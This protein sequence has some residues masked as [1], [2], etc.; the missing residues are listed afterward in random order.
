[1]QL[2]GDLTEAGTAQAPSPASGQGVQLNS[3]KLDLRAEALCDI[4]LLAVKGCLARRAGFFNTQISVGGRIAHCD[5][6]GQQSFR[7]GKC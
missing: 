3:C 5:A 6:P 4:P 1:M 2:M 7:C